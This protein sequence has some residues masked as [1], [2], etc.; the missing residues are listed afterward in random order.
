MRRWLIIVLLF[1][2]IRC[3]SQTPHQIDSTINQRLIHHGVADFTRKLI[4]SQARV[5]SGVYTNNLTV[6]IC[7]VHKDAYTNL[8][9]MLNPRQR[10][11]TSRGPCARAESRGGYACYGSIDKSVDDLI[12][13]LG[14]RELIRP[15]KT[16]AEYVTALRQNGYFSSSVEQ[17]IRAIQYQNKLQ[18]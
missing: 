16:T 2:T 7:Q 17:Y 13:W 4:I 1:T 12:L 18:K 5:E 14:A 9:G 8:F 15:Y 10:K 6:K 3:W 11:T